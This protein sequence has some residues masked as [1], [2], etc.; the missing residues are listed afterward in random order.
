MVDG[1]GGWGV[2]D[3][4][5]D[6]GVGVGVGFCGAFVSPGLR[7]VLLDVDKQDGLGFYLFL[8]LLR[9]LLSC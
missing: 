1:G 2:S 3:V 5:V 7:I 6:V 9:F 8:L 4:D